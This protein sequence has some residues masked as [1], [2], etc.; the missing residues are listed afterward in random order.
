[1]FGKSLRVL[2]CRR[3]CCTSQP[4]Q[5][6][7]SPQFLWGPL[8]AAFI[9]CAARAGGRGGRRPPSATLCPPP[10]RCAFPKLARGACKRS[11]LGTRF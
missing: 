10:P 6:P 3:R 4:A 1:M 8:R 5:G 9:V 11:A 7:P 2:I